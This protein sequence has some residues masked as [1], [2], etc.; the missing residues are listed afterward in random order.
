[1]ARMKTI[2]KKTSIAHDENKIKSNHYMHF[3]DKT[4]LKKNIIRH[5][6]HADYILFDWE[7][8]S[9]QLEFE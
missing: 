3:K 6:I 8:F 9:N 1:M 7:F 2:S 4:D 5:L